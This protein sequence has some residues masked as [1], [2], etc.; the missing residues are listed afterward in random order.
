MRSEYAGF[1]EEFLRAAAEDSNGL[2]QRMIPLGNETQILETSCSQ[3]ALDWSLV[4]PA[5][6]MRS[7]NRIQPEPLA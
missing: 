7:L 3:K 5:S 4:A 2:M 6:L 1:F